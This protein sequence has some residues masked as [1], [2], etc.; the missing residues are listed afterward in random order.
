MTKRKAWKCTKCGYISLDDRSGKKCNM[1][2]RTPGRCDSLYYEEI[3]IDTLTQDETATLVAAQKELLYIANKE[4]QKIRPSKEDCFGAIEMCDYLKSTYNMADD[5]YEI[6]GMLNNILSSVENIKFVSGDTPVAAFTY[7]MVGRKTSYTAGYYQISYDKGNKIS[8]YNLPSV[9]RMTEIDADV[10]S[11]LLT[12]IE[13][14]KKYKR[15]TRYH[16]LEFPVPD[17]C[18]YTLD[19]MKET[20][21]VFHNVFKPRMAQTTQAQRRNE[22]VEQVTQFVNTDPN[23]IET[24]ICPTCGKK[25]VYRI[26]NTQ[27][28]VSVGFFGLFSKNIGKTMECRACGYKW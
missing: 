27:R 21:Q 12:I 11:V 17:D 25:S 4:F 28:A 13:T 22:M 16:Y 24:A 6:A 15:G 3:E 23:W 8:D 5:I 14:V 2:K 9:E 19:E 1:L 10:N 26:T 7:V 18:D 20:R